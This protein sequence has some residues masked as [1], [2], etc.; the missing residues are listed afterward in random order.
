MPPQRRTRPRLPWPA[1]IQIGLST[2]LL[3]LFVVVIGRSREQQQ[4]LVRLQQRL[5]SLERAR[6]LEQAASAE[7]QVR[8]FADRLQALESQMAERQQQ[9]EAERLRLQRL[10]TELGSR[11]YSS[12][13][14]APRPQP[15][16]QEEVLPEA[17][18]Q[19]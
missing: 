14:T 9:S 6:T 1:L 2:M 7:G 13:S 19:P 4:E 18:R 10:I 16:G 12:S 3:V 17:E 15:G 11:S 5:Q 8:A